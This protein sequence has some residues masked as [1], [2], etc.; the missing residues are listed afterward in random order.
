MAH[1]NHNEELSPATQ[2]NILKMV[3]SWQ[4]G[5]TRQA[6]EAAGRELRWR[7]IRA[8]LVAASICIA[9]LISVAALRIQFGPSIGGA[10]VALVR[11]NGLIDAGS[12]A[13]AASVN[14]RLEQAFQDDA[15]KG[16]IVVINSPGGTPVQSSLI[17]ER[18]RTLRLAYPQ[19]KVWVVGQDMLTSGAYLAA[20]GA[21]HICVN[22]STLT[23]SIGVRMDGWGLQNLV[24][25]F[26]IERRS[27]SAGEHKERFDAYRRM[28]AD[29][30]VKVTELLAQLHRQFIEAVEQGRGRRIA[31]P[32]KVLYSGDV[33]SGEE[34]IRL[35]LVDGLCS[36]ES[37]MREEYGVSQFRDYSPAEPLLS[38]LTAGMMRSAAEDVRAQVTEE[39]GSWR[40]MLLP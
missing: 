24:R 16:V 14:P 12:P 4:E 9:P 37:L 31:G 36:L 19:R 29:D 13:G 35:G 40:P 23:G 21:D 34:A 5:Q 17:N 32:A 27:F 26:G 2:D 10:Y 7:N 8:V 38:K 15:A 39:S 30:K 25:R 22:R 11:I 3:L 18:L 28:S 20:V 6:A 33:W 1:P